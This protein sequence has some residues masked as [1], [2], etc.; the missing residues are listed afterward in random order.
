MFWFKKKMYTNTLVCIHGAFAGSG[1]YYKNFDGI[2]SSILAID[3]PGFGESDRPQFSSDP[4]SDWAQA[5]RSVIVQEVS[6]AFYILAHSLGCYLT[7]S[8]LVRQKTH[9]E[10]KSNLEGVI[11]L[12]PWGLNTESEKTML[13]VYNESYIQLKIMKGLMSIHDFVPL[14]VR[15]KVTNWVA[16]TFFPDGF[17]EKFYVYMLQEGD[18]CSST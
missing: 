16:K 14:W 15:R 18:W 3:L 7:A 5:I 12:D 1:E 11:L 6:G 2:N 10:I 9:T 17:E 8:M 13:N 4:E